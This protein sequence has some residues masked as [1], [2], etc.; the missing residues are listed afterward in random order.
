MRRRTRSKSVELR[1]FNGRR[2]RVK[3]RYFVLA[4]GA[5]E[6]ARLMLASDRIEPHG[7]GNRRDLVGRFFMEHPRDRI[8]SL[9]T[10]DPFHLIDMFRPGWCGELYLL[11]LHHRPC[12]KDEGRADPQ[13]PAS[14]PVR[15]R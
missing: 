6:N 2:A 9:T 4:C 5:I 1:S 3:A 14:A 13:H 11:P 7:I 12:G 8:G 15:D 10:D